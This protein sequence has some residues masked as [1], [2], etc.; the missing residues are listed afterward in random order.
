[1][2]GV[3]RLSP[4]AQVPLPLLGMSALLALTGALTFA[5]DLSG[6]QM[7]GWTLATLFALGGL[8]A[9]GA[10]ASHAP[11]VR[12]PP[13]TRLFIIIISRHPAF[14]HETSPRD[15]VSGGERS[16]AWMVWAGDSV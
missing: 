3:A 12:Q 15:C 1:M 13:L 6:N 5:R 11:R 4:L 16:C 2:G 9:G 10:K 8:T 7:M 14:Q